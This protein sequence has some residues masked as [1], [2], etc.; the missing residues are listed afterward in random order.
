MPSLARALSCMT[1]FLTEDKSILKVASWIL[2]I[3]LLGLAALGGLIYLIAP[4]LWGDLFGLSTAA[5]SLAAFAGA[6]GLGWLWHALRRQRDQEPVS[7]SLPPG[8]MWLLAGG[9]ALAGGALV[10]SGRLAGYLLPPL[11]V[12]ALVS[13][14]GLLLAAVYR[15]WGPLTGREWLAQ[16]TYGGMGATLLSAIFEVMAFM[17][18][19][20]A[21]LLALAVLPGG[22]AWLEQLLS[23]LQALMLSEDPALLGDWIGS[24]P[25]AIGL[26]LLL[27]VLVPLI[28]ESVKTL[29]VLWLG[30]RQGG[31]SQMALWGVLSGLGFGLVETFL[32]QVAMMGS[33]WIAL[34]GARTL[35]MLLHGVTGGLVGLGWY[36]WRR[37]GQFLRFLGC[38]AAA[39]LL[40]AAWN[41]TV[42][43]IMVLPMWF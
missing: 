42:V 35:A 38:F 34:V 8:W 2:A 40:H 36:Y 3:V 22:Q 27:A 1:R 43:L 33:S 9:I 21:L 7:I 16:V 39:I 18:L 11:N 4:L 6:L 37:E 10:Q 29:G 19:A 17:L 14:A 31:R 28:E 25:V 41:G 32:N 12:V 24:L 13:M 26:F 20:M 5:F 30:W 23:N 15:H